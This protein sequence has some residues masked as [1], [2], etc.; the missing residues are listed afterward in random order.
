MSPENFR[1]MTSRIQWCI[2]HW[3]GICHEI[4]TYFKRLDL[5]PWLIPKTIS[6]EA[7]NSLR[8]PNSNLMIYKLTE[9]NWSNRHSVSIEGGIVLSISAKPIA[10]IGT[11]WHVFYFP[12]S[13]KTVS[14]CVKKKNY[15]LNPQLDTSS[16]YGTSPGLSV[17]NQ[18][19]TLVKHYAS[20]HRIIDQSTKSH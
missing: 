14:S 20:Q 12:L 5:V 4:F 19:I 15:K 6:D 13:S 1:P 16:V 2:L 3:N 10:P 11:Q 8:S 18:M 7:L 9:T 17:I